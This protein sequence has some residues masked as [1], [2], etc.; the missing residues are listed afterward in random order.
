[1]DKLWV[2]VEGNHTGSEALKLLFK[3]AV[4]QDEDSGAHRASACREIEVANTDTVNINVAVVTTT[5]CMLETRS[6]CVSV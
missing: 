5:D 6:A 4:S 1:M 2:G 3:S